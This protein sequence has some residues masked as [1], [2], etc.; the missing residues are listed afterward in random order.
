[1]TI[2]SMNKQKLFLNLAIFTAASLLLASVL[3]KNIVITILAMA[4]AL[5]A[6]HV[7]R[8]I[9][10]RKF[11]TYKELLQEKYEKK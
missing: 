10:P 9:Y 6:Q 4:I 11:R 7:Y 1:M 3:T 5:I 2:I 8:K